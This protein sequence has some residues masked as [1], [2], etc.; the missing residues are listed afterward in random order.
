MS[1]KVWR[2]TTQHQYYW[3]DGNGN[4]ID[5]HSVW[6]SNQGSFFNAIVQGTEDQIVVHYSEIKV[7]RI[8]TVDSVVTTNAS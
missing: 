5:L 4:R 1:N 7:E 3:Q 2:T 6:P 8:S